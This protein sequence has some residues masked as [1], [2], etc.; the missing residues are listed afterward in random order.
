MDLKILF[1]AWQETASEGGK[2]SDPCNA[3]PLEKGKGK[4]EDV[5]RIQ[6]VQKKKN[7]LEHIWAIRE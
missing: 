7:G 6:G 5:T 3:A 2:E 1:F 4:K